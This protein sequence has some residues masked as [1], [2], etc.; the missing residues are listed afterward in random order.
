MLNIFEMCAT[1]ATLPMCSLHSFDICRGSLKIKP[2]YACIM[3]HMLLERSLNYEPI[4]LNA[5]HKSQTG[6][7]KQ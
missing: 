1:F 5:S 3:V 7:L 4:G 6:E 2:T